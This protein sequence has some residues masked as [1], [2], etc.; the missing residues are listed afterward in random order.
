MV[1]LHDIGMKDS[2]DAAPYSPAVHGC[3][4]QSTDGVQK[5]WTRHNE[6]H[7]R[8]PRQIAHRLRRIAGLNKSSNSSS[9]STDSCGTIS[10]KRQAR[11]TLV[12]DSSVKAEV[13]SIYD[14]I[15]P[16]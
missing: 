2:V 12:N 13:T 15:A 1:V 14:H 6:A 8:L 7:G 10:R 3:V 5:T 9:N 16:F 11:T 4:R